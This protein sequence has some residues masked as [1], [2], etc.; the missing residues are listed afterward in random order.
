MR[1]S[2]CYYALKLLVCQVSCCPKKER[3]RGRMQWARGFGP[4]SLACCRLG[5]NRMPPEK[6][7]LERAESLILQLKILASDIRTNANKW[8]RAV[9]RGAKTDEYKNT[10]KRLGLERNKI[11]ALIGGVMNDTWPLLEKLEERDYEA[12]VGFKRGL[13]EL[14]LRVR[15]T[16][17]T[18]VEWVEDRALAIA[19]F[20]R[21]LQKAEITNV[22][23]DGNAR[24]IPDQIIEDDPNQL[25]RREK[26]ET[27]VDFIDRARKAKKLTIERLAARA[28]VNPAQ[29]Y[30]IKGGRRVTSGTLGQVSAALGCRTDDLIKR[31]ILR[32]TDDLV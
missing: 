11:D 19:I 6:T 32:P 9:S 22:S 1:C 13:K 2:Y 18:D 27:V 28:G 16:D 23:K 25:L 4:R 7:P 29:I 5:T 3:P 8:S 10:A 12:A 30:R 21:E 14:V 24:G 20:L 15:P 17:R 31:P 26:N